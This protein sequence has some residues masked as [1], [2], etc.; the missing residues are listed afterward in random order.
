MRC[1][2]S[3]FLNKCNQHILSGRQQKINGLFKFDLFFLYPLLTTPFR[4]INFNGLY[5]TD[6]IRLK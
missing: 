5:Y 6:A 1:S 3:F 4:R 2:V